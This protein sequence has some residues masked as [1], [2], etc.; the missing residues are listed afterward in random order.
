M[1]EAFEVLFCF[2]V[3]LVDVDSTWQF[4]VSEWHGAV[5]RMGLRKERLRSG[6]PQACCNNLGK[7][8]VAWSGEGASEVGVHEGNL[9]EAFQRKMCLVLLWG[10]MRQEQE[11]RCSLRSEPLVQVPAEL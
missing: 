3:F 11:S 5:C 1:D 9:E 4:W 10:G 7:D 6:G 8:V 2:F